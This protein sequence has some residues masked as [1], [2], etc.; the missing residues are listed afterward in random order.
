MNYIQSTSPLGSYHHVYA[1]ISVIELV[2]SELSQSASLSQQ[3]TVDLL[4]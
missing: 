4:K 2:I 1:D 3:V